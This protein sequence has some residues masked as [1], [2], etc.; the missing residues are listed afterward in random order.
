MSVLFKTRIT[1]D[2]INLLQ[3]FTQR[4]IYRPNDEHSNLNFNNFIVCNYSILFKC[5]AFTIY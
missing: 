2:I 1:N 3:K 4:A 5:E